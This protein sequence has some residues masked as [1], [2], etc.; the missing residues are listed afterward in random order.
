MYI[1]I[2]IHHVQYG[3]VPT[4]LALYIP[5]NIYLQVQKEGRYFENV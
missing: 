2:P 1:C 5:L 4:V 3:T